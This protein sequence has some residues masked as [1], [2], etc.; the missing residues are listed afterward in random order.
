MGCHLFA[1]YRLPILPLSLASSLLS[2]CLSTAEGQLMVSSVDPCYCCQCHQQSQR[3]SQR[4]E[5]KQNHHNNNTKH[6]THIHKKKQQRKWPLICA[7]FEIT[8]GSIYQLNFVTSVIIP[9]SPA[10]SDAA[11]H[12]FVPG[13]ILVIRTSFFII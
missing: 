10:V 13:S 4:R 1:Y 6:N 5:S 7:L 2:F 8:C 3:P 11:C 9:F 12:Q